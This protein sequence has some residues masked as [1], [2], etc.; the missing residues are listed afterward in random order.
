V[1]TCAT[2]NSINA[3][4]FLTCYHINGKKSQ[5]CVLTAFMCQHS[6]HLKMKGFNWN[7]AWRNYNCK[8]IVLKSSCRL[9]QVDHRVLKN[10]TKFKKFVWNKNPNNFSISNIILYYYNFCSLLPVLFKWRPSKSQN[11]SYA[12]F[13][14]PEHE[15]IE[16]LWSVVV[17]RR[18]STFDVYTLETT[19]VIRFLWNLVRM[20]VLTI[21]KFE[22]RSCRVN[23]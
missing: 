23:N 3:K 8:D 7:S 5:I 21:S 18:P 17:R 20:F 4:E 6:S 22:Y 19:F 9:H 1:L 2:N 15:V 11:W 10:N 16:L 13:S 14:S 12:M